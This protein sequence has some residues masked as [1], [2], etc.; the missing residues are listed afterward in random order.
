LQRHRLVY[1][2]LGTLMETDIHAVQLTALTPQQAQA[3]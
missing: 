3:K 2:A 1:E